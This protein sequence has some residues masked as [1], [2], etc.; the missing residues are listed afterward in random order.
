MISTNEGPQ[1][2]KRNLMLLLYNYKKQSAKDNFFVTYSSFESIQELD[3]FQEVHEKNLN[4][5]RKLLNFD[6]FYT[7][8]AHK[9]RT[10]NNLNIASY[11]KN[12]KL[13]DKHKST[14]KLFIHFVKKKT[15]K[16]TAEKQN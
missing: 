13:I 5:I 11:Q 8:A 3:W 1:P 6:S 4:E 15:S 14:K 10:L 12:I 16:R 2:I 9:V 7:F